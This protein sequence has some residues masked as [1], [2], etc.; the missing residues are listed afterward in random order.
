MNYTKGDLNDMAKCDLIEIILSIQETKFDITKIS[1]K[2]ELSSMSLNKMKTI[3]HNFKLN[4]IGSKKILIDRIWG[5]KYPDLMPEDAKLKKRGRKSNT[6]KTCNDD[7]NNLIIDYNK[8]KLNMIRQQ[9][10][11]DDLNSLQKIFASEN[12][13][14]EKIKDDIYYQLFYISTNNNIYSHHDNKYFYE[15]KSDSELRR[16]IFS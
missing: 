4:T 13:S 16:I 10:N 12:G 5:I 1:S 14:F 3:C 2:E 9:I 7:V 8:E 11:K 6:I 15:G